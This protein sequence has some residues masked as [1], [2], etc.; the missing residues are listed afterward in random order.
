MP[1]YSR[2]SPRHWN[3]VALALL[4]A[5]PPAL[6]AQTGVI[7]GKVTDAATRGPLAGV[8][9]LI[10]GTSAATQTN[11]DG[12]YR[13][14]NLRP[15][16]M[17]VRL[18]RLGYKAVS[19]TVRLQA[20]E[21]VARDYQMVASLVNLSEVVVTGTAGNQERRAQ[22]AVV[23]SVD[24][25]N[26][27]KDAPITSV[28]ELLQSRLPGVEV[29]TNSGSTGTARTIRIRG[30]A[31]INLSNQPLLFIDGVRINEQQTDGG[32]GGQAYDRLNDLDPN[33]IESIEVVKGPAAATLYGADASAGVIQVITKK[34]HAGSN[35]FVQSI[36][37]EGGTS[38]ANWTPPDNYAKC[39]ASSVLATST[40]PLCRGQA[41]GTLVHDN[42]LLRVGAF[43]T[44][45]DRQVGWSARGGGQN[46]GYNLSFNTSNT[47][48]TLPNNQFERYNIRTNYNYAPNSKLTIE[49]G[50]GLAQSL[51]T[52]PPN[53][54]NSFGWIGGALLGSPLSLSDGPNAQAGN[55]G[56]FNRQHY[57][58]KIV[59]DNQ[60]LTHRVTTNLTANYLP[61]SWFTNR[62]TVGLDYAQDESHNFLP[63]NDSLWFG[64]LNDGGFIQQFRIDAER[65]T[66]DYLGNMRS[67]FG[68][69][70]QWE[71]NFS[72]GLQVI[73]SRNVNVNATGIGLVTN[74]N[75]SIDAAATNTG[76]GNFTEQRQYG[77]LSQLQLGY[78]NRMFVQF[79]VRVDKN[80]S[81]GT[82]S[83]SFVLPK[84]GA[85]WTVS[86]ERWFDPL[87]RVFSSLRARAAWGTTGRSPAPGAALTTLTAQ[88]YNII[89]V[90]NAGA[91]PGNP[92]NPTLKPERG[93]EY[94][95][96]FD[97][98]FLK[99]RVSA[100]LTYFHKVTKDL[101]IA[102]PIPPSLGFQG[103]KNGNNANPLANLGSVLNSG[104]ELALNVNAV[105]T[106][107]F[108]WDIRAGGNTL[109]NELTSLGGQS[110]FAVGQGGRILEG[111]QLGVFVSKKIRSIDVANSKVIVND[112]LT[113]IGNLWPT[114][115]WS[116]TNSVTLFKYLRLSALLDSKRDFFVQN[117][118]AYFRE[119]QIVR[120]NARLDPTVLSPYERLRR[121][122]D[123]TPGN[124]A[125]VTISGQ[126]ET[127]SNVVDAFTQPGDFTR[128]REVSATY[129]LPGS[130]LSSIRNYVTSASITL[131]MQNVKLWTRYGGAD[132]EVVSDAGQFSRFDFL[133][134]PN[135]K[136]TILR[137]NLTF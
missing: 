41:V 72:F 65:Y 96:G 26:V 80:S 31:S 45:T 87:K 116:L 86:E 3:A 69:T 53:D 110:P 89:G 105:D 115:E 14:T 56:W 117:F 97:A 15:G 52:L 118:T 51:V 38:D 106:K 8:Q 121:Y 11:V 114:L 109:H 107:N 98:S 9:V 43:R 135:P 22:S 2:V 74:A 35:Q 66:V 1:M 81:F 112:T 126:P 88:P 76:A 61:F 128:L 130:V 101:I 21:T 30:A 17:T 13:L 104:L 57:A 127:V 63:K 90:T 120:S 99:E 100:E 77:Y 85:T 6:S 36:R 84:V 94:E 58:G 46:Y 108:S 18:F 19:D 10:P 91:V 33:E 39:T 92:G 134:Q 5:V 102:R 78:S 62:V 124:P 75:N 70:G 50:L 136:T 131:A 49:A 29:T 59:Q 95:A 55:D 54:N 133:T 68:A 23:A 93:I 123:P 27:I 34:G 7:S 37:V 44:G 32:V 25:S 113:P 103:D 47:L 111:Q 79:G 64:G 82:Q 119:T 137:M 132:P 48:G 4:L 20:G 71:T 83:P 129:T 60:Q 42:P 24:A 67:T 12:D 122:G 28:G 16:R 40:S 73:T 125:F